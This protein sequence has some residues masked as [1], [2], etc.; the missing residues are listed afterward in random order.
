MKRGLSFF[1]AILCYAILYYMTFLFLLLD[2]LNLSIG[3]FFCSGDVHDIAPGFGV[4]H[5]L[6]LFVF[7][8]VLL[9]NLELIV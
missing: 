4:Q 1:A 5:Y 8:I 9:V 6:I 2:A 7:L 3:P